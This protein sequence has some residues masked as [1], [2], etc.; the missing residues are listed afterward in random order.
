[1]LKH[2]FI[3]LW[4][5]EKI[6]CS[7]TISSQLVWQCCFSTWILDVYSLVCQHSAF[8]LCYITVCYF[9]FLLF[10]ETAD[11][12]GEKTCILFTPC[13]L[14]SPLL[15][16][17]AGGRFICLLMYLHSWHHCLGCYEGELKFWSFQYWNG[18]NSFWRNQMV[19]R[20]LPCTS[21]V[22]FTVGSIKRI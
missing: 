9:F 1:M 2:T 20:S 14:L 15:W 7:I 18:S 13:F 6:S 17:L 10:T 22:N 5:T 3:E 12:T 21:P 8:H 4:L 11:R 16:A 19:S